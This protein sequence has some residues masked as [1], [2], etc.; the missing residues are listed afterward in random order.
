MD[1]KKNLLKYLN[2][3][4]KIVILF[5]VL[6][7][8]IFFYISYNNKIDKKNYEE[9][10]IKNTTINVELSEKATTNEFINI[11]WTYENIDKIYINS[12]IVGISSWFFM[13]NYK[14]EL[15]DN[16]INIVWKNQYI[17]KKI[18]KKIERITLDEEKSRIQEQQEK[19]AIKKENEL[20]EIEIKKQEKLEREFYNKLVLVQDKANCE[21]E[22]K[23]PTD[24]DNKIF[25]YWNTYNESLMNKNL[26][27]NYELSKKL[28]TKYSNELS[29]IYNIS[30]ERY[31]EI[32]YKAF[33]ENWPLPKKSKC[34]KNY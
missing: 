6:I 27:L 28:S 33:K 13:Y 1:K 23:Y 31:S 32:N 25:W 4:I 19:L 10:F 15:W 22:I 16:I 29:K 21:A 18:T 24:I 9:Q 17:E 12:K 11:R 34:H 3:Y 20:I 30:N 7:L 8:L 5:I 26:E 2:K 14:L